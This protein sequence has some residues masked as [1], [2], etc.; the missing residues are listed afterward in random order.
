MASVQKQAAQFVLDSVFTDEDTKKKGEESP[1]LL[2]PLL[3]IPGFIFNSIFDSTEEDQEIGELKQ[4]IASSDGSS[5]RRVN[6]IA[7]NRGEDSAGI[8]FK[9]RERRK[10]QLEKDLGAIPTNDPR[11][12]AL[13]KDLKKLTDSE[14]GQLMDSV[15]DPS[16][17][18]REKTL[19][20]DVLS[21]IDMS[22]LTEYVNNTFGTS[23]KNTPPKRN[24]DEIISTYLQ[25]KGNEKKAKAKML[26][27]MKDYDNKITN[28]RANLLK[29]GRLANTKQR[30]AK[31]KESD[32]L[33]KADID[34]VLAIDQMNDAA[35]KFGELVDPSL[36][37][38]GRSQMTSFKNLIYSGEFSFTQ[39]EAKRAL[40]E[41]IML[42][43]KAQQGSR[44]SDK[45]MDMVR[46][47]FVNL[48]KLQGKEL[49]ASTLIMF[50]R[51]NRVTRRR[52]MVMPGIDPE[53][54]IL[55][56]LPFPALVNDD[57]TDFSMAQ[58][59]DEAGVSAD[60][61]T[62]ILFDSEIGPESPLGKRMA[63]ER[64][65]FRKRG[66]PS[67]T[68]RKRLPQAKKKGLTKREQIAKDASIT[69]TD[70][71]LKATSTKPRP[72]TER[73][74]KMERLQRSQ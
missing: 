8:I 18:I 50:Q 31:K 34:A 35:A 74:L 73:E 44:A 33:Q 7:R 65:K 9:L 51:L 69:L 62:N 59:L 39:G 67:F 48:D 58:I 1:G 17:P 43:V 66:D 22:S 6:E 40:S 27:G 64:S 25:D 52:L 55:G 24:P 10:K 71:E 63:A 42:T 4:R 30:E 54:D 5:K 56:R 37:G 14:K 49:V 28:Q 12:A 32:K 26:L 2:D 15:L 11:F 53:T 29:I 72:K 23:F 61:N 36:A 70:E 60:F 13:A 41:A 3:A 46:D 20:I 68:P 47:A 45:D 21:H 38:F 19:A 16:L 57:G